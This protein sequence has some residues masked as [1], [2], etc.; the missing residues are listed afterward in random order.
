MQLF[1]SIPVHANEF[2]N[3]R[4][5][6]LQCFLECFH[7][8]P[9]MRKKQTAHAENSR[10]WGFHQVG[11][12]CH[13][14][15]AHEKCVQASLNAVERIF[16][17]FFLNIKSKD[18]Q[19]DQFASWFIMTPVAGSA[20]WTATTWM[21][22]WAAWQNRRFK[23][24]LPT[25]GGR[26]WCALGSSGVPVDCEEVHPGTIRKRRWKMGRPNYESREIWHLQNDPKKFQ[27]VLGGP[28]LNRN[29]ICT[30][31]LVHALTFPHSCQTHPWTRVASLPL[32]G[33]AGGW[34]AKMTWAPSSST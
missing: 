29:T 18:V 34:F 24:L 2:S 4:K 13:A 33:L 11:P 19:A 16:M 9:Q 3:S 25:C 22:G 32:R 20:S 21:V 30:D 23:P 6:R 27:P 15:C 28:C 8:R 14:S 31:L 12:H 1:W 7:T 17:T 5:A 26:R 10:R